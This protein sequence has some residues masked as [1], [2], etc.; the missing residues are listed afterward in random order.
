MGNFISSIFENEIFYIILLCLLVLS[1]NVGFNYGISYL[2]IF[3]I[4]KFL[5]S[6][7][8]LKYILIL[9]LLLYNYFIFRLIIIRLSFMFQFF[10]QIVHIYMIRQDFIKKI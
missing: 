3:L 5:P 8:Y 10:P 7:F 6:Y 1:I 9:I 2:Y 4:D